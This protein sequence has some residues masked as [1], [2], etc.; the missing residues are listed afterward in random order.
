MAHDHD[1]PHDHAHATL[2]D[3]DHGHHAGHRDNNLRAAYVHVL[4]DAATSVLAIGG[5]LLAR[6]F[7]WVWID[8]VVGLVGACV[9]ASWAY[10]LMRDAGAVLLDAVPNAK[11]AKTIR[12]R[13]E[14][15]GD[16][17]SDLHL[18]Q[19]GPGHQSAIISVVT[20]NPQEPSFY[21]A[22]LSGIRGLSHITVE[23]DRCPHPHLHG[24]TGLAA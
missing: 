17:I 24:D 4:A 20:D 11:I 18:W 8:P 5:L 22:R 15:E 21:K 23:V 6:S 9:I 3:H 14:V 19:V 12:H 10:G 13:L 1:H 2:K 7:G 16:R